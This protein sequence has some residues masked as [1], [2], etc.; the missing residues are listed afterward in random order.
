MADIYG[1]HFEFSGISSRA[2]NLIIANITTDRFTSLSGKPKSN[3]MYYRKSKE[4][5]ILNDSY[6]DSHLEFDIE[7]INENNDIIEY[8]QRRQIEKWLFNKHNY[9]KLYLDKKDD[10][11]G[12]TYEIVNGEE[13]RLYINCR[14]VDCQ[15]L[16][17]NGGIIG[18]KAIVETDSPFL[19]QEPITIDFTIPEEQCDELKEFVVNVD[20]DLDDYIYPKLIIGGGKTGGNIEVFNSSDLND[21]NHMSYKGIVFKNLPA[22]FTLFMDGDTNF[23]NNYYENFHSRSFLRLVPGENLIYVIGDISYIQFM[24]Q[25]RRML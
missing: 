8:T 18:Y 23:V 21:V 24:W 3:T 4:K 14:F 19:W 9:R 25:N 12:E 10:Y 1:S 22:N 2:Y 11:N 15:K 7:I 13:K 5:I 20:T 17:F 16:E 6:E